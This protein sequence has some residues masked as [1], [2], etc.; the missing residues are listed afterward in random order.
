MNKYPEKFLKHVASNSDIRRILADIAW[1]MSE[2]KLNQE[3]YDNALKEEYKIWLMR[4][5]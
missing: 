5:R 2:G 4:N 1:K 3:H